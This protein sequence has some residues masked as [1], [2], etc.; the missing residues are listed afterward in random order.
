MKIQTKHYRFANF[1]N[2]FG[3]KRMLG[4]SPASLEAL[5]ES[6]QGEI[7]RELQRSGIPEE[8]RDA[9]RRKFNDVFR[10][11]G[12]AMRQSSKS[13]SET[14]SLEGVSDDIEIAR[15]QFSEAMERLE[16]AERVK[17]EAQNIKKEKVPFVKNLRRTGVVAGSTAFIPPYMAS[18]GGV[19][20]I[21]A[22]SVTG[23]IGAYM[24]SKFLPDS[25]RKSRMALGAAAGVASAPIVSSGLTY[26][27][28]MLSAATNVVAG[29]LFA[30]SGGA[31]GYVL[32]RRA[33]KGEG[34]GGPMNEWKANAVALPS[35]V[36]IGALSGYLGSTSIATKGVSALGS[37]IAWLGSLFPTFSSSLSGAVSAGSLGLATGASAAGLYG[38]G[39]FEGKVWKRDKTGILGNIGRAMISPA[40]IPAALLYKPT[41]AIFNSTKRTTGLN[42]DA[43]KRIFKGESPAVKA[44]TSPIWWPTRT[45]Y[46]LGRGVVK[47]VYNGITNTSPSEL[48]IA[49]GISAKITRWPLEKGAGAIRKTFWDFPRYMFTKR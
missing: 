24:G 39:R 33:C 47:G 16:A 23:G 12:E 36:G 49:Q 46:R 44:V 22:S 29:P 8:N 45:A 35:A 40:T 37:G 31:A 21:A 32:V 25:M 26:G 5:P 42:W 9:L 41:K 17:G 20:Q 4:M 18:L 10:R 34:L 27:G 7:E 2:L 48:D 30:L 38:L 3:E 15:K 1:E 14:P 13:E 11:G 43:T 6:T 19:S 28:T